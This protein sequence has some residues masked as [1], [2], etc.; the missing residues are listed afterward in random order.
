VK[1][2]NAQTKT[3]LKRGTKAAL[4][5]LAEKALR[6]E[7]REI[8]GLSIILVDNEYIRG[9][10][11]KFLGKDRPTDVMAFPMKN[12]EIYVS[13]EYVAGDHLLRE[14][15]RSVLHGILHLV[16]YEHGKGERSI[17][18]RETAYEAE[19]RESF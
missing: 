14:L 1:I 6:R 17:E 16:G 19:L 11:H 9:L 10:N 3:P 18:V 8:R 2:I 5:T 7:G 4:R 13:V 15:K 12:P